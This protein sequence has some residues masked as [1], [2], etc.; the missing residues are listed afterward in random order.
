[1]LVLWLIK[2]FAIISCVVSS[3]AN[4]FYF[5]KEPSPLL[6]EAVDMEDIEDEEKMDYP[7]VTTPNKNLNVSY[8]ETPLPEKSGKKDGT[9]GSRKTNVRLAPTFCRNIFQLNLKQVIWLTNL[10]YEMTHFVFSFLLQFLYFT[11]AEK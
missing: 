9:T 1:M 6:P 8:E 2:K 11:V 5:L 7:L 4:C 3:L 10:F